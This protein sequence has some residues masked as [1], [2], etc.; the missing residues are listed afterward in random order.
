[1]H[2]VGKMIEN[3]KRIKINKCESSIGLSESSIK[4]FNHEIL[5]KIK[6]FEKKCTF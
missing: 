4:S 5:D 6:E 3:C 1:M 2:S